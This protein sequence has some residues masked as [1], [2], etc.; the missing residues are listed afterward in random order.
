MTKYSSVSST[1]MPSGREAPERSGSAIRI[2]PL[3]LPAYSC[4]KSNPYDIH[5][6]WVFAKLIMALDCGAFQPFSCS[7]INNCRSSSAEI[8]PKSATASSIAD[9]GIFSNISSSISTTAR[10]TF[11]PLSFD[12]LTFLDTFL[13]GALGLVCVL[14]L[15][16][17]GGPDE[18]AVLRCGGD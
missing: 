2:P 17:L 10:R 5:R 16:N 9:F 4:F 13:L 12:F 1:S 14:S 11:T 6:D 8:S 7:F 15:A 18:G 3:L